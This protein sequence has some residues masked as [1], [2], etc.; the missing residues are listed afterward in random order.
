MDPT[1]VGV[2][3]WDLAML[4]CIAGG[5][6]FHRCVALTALPALKQ[7]A[8]GVQAGPTAWLHVGSYSPPVA[9]ASCVASS[10]ACAPPPSPGAALGGPSALPCEHPQALD[11]DVMSSGPLAL[12]APNQAVRYWWLQGMQGQRTRGSRQMH[13]WRPGSRQLAQPACLASAAAAV[14]ACRGVHVRSCYCHSAACCA[15]LVVLPGS[16][17]ST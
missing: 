7:H 8:V 10:T 17:L 5:R 13:S 11:L 9:P 1:S 4:A 14:R 15:H 3:C 12:H 2:C 16:T 6:C